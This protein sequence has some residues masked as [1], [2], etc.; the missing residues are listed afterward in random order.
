M[1]YEVITNVGDLRVVWRWSAANFGPRPEARSEVTPL[2]VGGVIYATAGITRNIVAIDAR[3][4]ETLWLWR[5]EEG[6]RYD[7]APR[8]MAGRGVAYWT[9]GR[10]VV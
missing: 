9:D 7:A 5:P 6:E 10:G 1:L 8:K 3:S 4:G 2:M